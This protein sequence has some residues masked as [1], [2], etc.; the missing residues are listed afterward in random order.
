MAVPTKKN[1]PIWLRL[2]TERTT[3]DEEA[4]ITLSDATTGENAVV[5]DGGPGGFDPTTGGPAGGFPKSCELPHA[6]DG[7]VTGP[8]LRGT[9]SI[10][11]RAARFPINVSVNQDVRLCDVTLTLRGP[12]GLEYAKLHKVSLSAGEHKLF[13]PRLRTIVPGR[14]VLRVDALSSD[15]K[16][17]K[18]RSA[19]SGRLTK[20]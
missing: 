3:G 10:F 13:L 20:K 17:V 6:E 12:S 1:Q 5:V 7:G 2:G 15:R 9:V 18:V 11:N 4:S 8:D 19:V 14:F 16:L